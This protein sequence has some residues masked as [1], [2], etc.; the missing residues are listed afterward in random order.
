MISSEQYFGFKL[1][2]APQEHRDNALDL[3]GKVNALLAYAATLSTCGYAWDTDTDTGTCIAGAKGGAGDGG[4]RLE[5]AKTGTAHSKH[6]A[7]NAVDV[8]DRGNKLDNWL[9]DEILERFELWRERPEITAGWAHLQ[10]VV[11]LT[12]KR[13]S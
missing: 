12:G 3:L 6:K 5:N 10:R 4:Y 13:T 1:P 2:F 11:T 9:T 7:G 8:F